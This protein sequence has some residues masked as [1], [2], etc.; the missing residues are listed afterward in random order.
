MAWTIEGEVTRVTVDTAKEGLAKLSVTLTD[1]DADDSD[2][3]NAVNLA[4]A[5]QGQAS[6]VTVGE[7]EIRGAW[8]HGVRIAPGPDGTRI[9]YTIR[10]TARSG[11]AHELA[12]HLAFAYGDF[13]EVRGEPVQAEL[14][15][16]DDP[17]QAFADEIAAEMRARAVAVVDG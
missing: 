11:T 9:A 1:V 15:L 2:I 8:L 13:V 3:A 12:A 7:V 17:H 16:R 4:A 5:Y 14:P 6:V 10:A